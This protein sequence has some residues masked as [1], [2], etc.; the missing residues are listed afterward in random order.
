MAQVFVAGGGPSGIAA[1]VSAARRGVDTILVERY[2]FLGGMATAGL[3]NP[4]M[5]WFAGGRPLVGGILDEMLTRM[6][7]LGGYDGGERAPHAFDPEAFKFAAD[8]LCREAGV[9]V[10]LHTLVTEVRRRDGRIT[11]LAT[12]SKSGRESWRARLVIDC[13]GDADIAFRAGVPCDHGRPEDGLTQPMTLNFRM[14]RVDVPRMPAREEVNR[15]YDLAKAE[16]RVHCPRENVLLFFTTQPDVV[17]FNTTRVTGKSGT[18][19]EDLTAA[20]FEARRQVVE[21]VRF[22]VR[23]VPGFEHAYLQQIGTQIGIR[24]SRRIGGD[25]A[26]TGDDVVSARK[27]PD[28]IARSN[29]PIDIH[30]P[31]GA[32]TVIR[33]VPAGDYYEIPYRCL[34]PLGIE[35][36]LV[37]GRAISSTHEGQ[38]SLRVMPQCFA[39]GQAAGTAAAMAVKARLTPRQ[40]D[41]EALR[42]ALREQGQIV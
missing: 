18:S 42:T 16:G 25:Y 2:G 24:E 34:L 19:A 35:N 37:V 23:D 32:G 4:F 30:N 14:A 12:E 8:Q 13:T 17:H 33:D 28:G 5:S 40:V 6:R 36:L 21:L 31:A 11:S 39:M 29:Y 3:V 41:P 22:L 1:A 27:F 15:R 20:E 38:S 26:L 9:K 10:R 7:A